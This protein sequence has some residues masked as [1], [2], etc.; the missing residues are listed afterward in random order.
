MKK[1]MIWKVILLVLPLVVVLIASNPASVMIF[2]GE[3]LTYTSW[4]LATSESAV[5]L[6]APV[7]ALINY[8]LFALAVFYA[9]REKDGCLKAMSILALAAACIAV[10]PIMVQSEPKIVPNVFGAIALGTEG[11]VARIVLKN[12]AGKDKNESAGFRINR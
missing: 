3:T 8:A 1:H 2:D 9:L 6:C 5:G 7:A 11:I 12:A 10:L 4:M